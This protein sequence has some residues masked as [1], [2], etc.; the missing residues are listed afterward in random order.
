MGKNYCMAKQNDNCRPDF[1]YCN[2]MT[3]GYTDRV[4]RKPDDLPSGIPARAPIFLFKPSAVS[5]RKYNGGLRKP[6]N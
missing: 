2:G 6:M 5:R 1:R 4:I 3:C